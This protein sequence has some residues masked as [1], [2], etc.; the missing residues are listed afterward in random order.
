MLFHSDMRQLSDFHKKK[1]IIRFLKPYPGDT[2][3][4]TKTE[5]TYEESMH[6]F[7]FQVNQT[8]YT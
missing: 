7:F 2:N 5:D 8:G 3:S 1:H 6:D 4:T